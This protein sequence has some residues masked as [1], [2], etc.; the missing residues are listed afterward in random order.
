LFVLLVED[1]LGDATLMSILL[2]EST[3]PLELVHVHNGEEALDFIR[4]R[5]PEDRPDLILLDLKMPR[6]DGLDFLRERRK[7]KTISSIPTIV[8]TGSDARSDK[9]TAMELGADMY[10]MKPANIDEADT[11]VPTIEMFIKRQKPGYC[12]PV[13]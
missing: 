9:E 13:L 11:L 10:I 4:E 6:M 7:D 2:E 3:C 12:S 8:L 1:N 5:K